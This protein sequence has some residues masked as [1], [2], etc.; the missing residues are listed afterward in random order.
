MIKNILILI[1]NH[2]VIVN[3]IFHMLLILYFINIIIQN[4]KL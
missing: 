4:Y 2:F 1:F 3:E